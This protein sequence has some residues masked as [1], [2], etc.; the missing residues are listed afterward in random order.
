MRLRLNPIHPDPGRPVPVDL[1]QAKNL[2][3]ELPARMRA[4]VDNLQ[5]A[6]RE[7]LQLHSVRPANDPQLRRHLPIPPAAA[8]TRKHQQAHPPYPLSHVILV[9]AAPI[10]AVLLHQYLC[11][12]LL[13]SEWE[14]EWVDGGVVAGL[15]L[16]D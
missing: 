4:P 14:C 16:Y 5:L 10:L 8:L 2:L 9:L 7:Q 11:D 1:Q 13:Y 12:Q 15:F 6:N 3:H